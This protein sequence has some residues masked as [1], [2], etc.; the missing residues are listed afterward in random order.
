MTYLNYYATLSEPLAFI[1]G[2]WVY[3]SNISH[4]HR[5]VWHFR[6]SWKQSSVSCSRCHVVVCIF[7]FMQQSFV[8]WL[9]KV[10][11]SMHRAVLYTTCKSQKQRLLISKN[12]KM[13]IHIIS[14]LR[15]T[16]LGSLVLLQLC[17]LP[18]G[19][20]FSQRKLYKCVDF[21]GQKTFCHSFLSSYRLARDN[22]WM[23]SLWLLHT[24]MQVT[25]RCTQLPKMSMGL[26]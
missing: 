14:Y 10:R 8:C 1:M 25:I 15:Q 22:R 24:H 17:H 6:L 20:D 5:C 21:Y 11:H 3:R 16:V 9:I 23:T 13:W 4:V 7:A 12:R 26:F 18:R 2:M 19:W